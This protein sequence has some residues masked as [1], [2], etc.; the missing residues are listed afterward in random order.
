MS[1]DPQGSTSFT[2]AARASAGSSPEIVGSGGLFFDFDNDGWLDVFLV[3]GGSL[4]DGVAV[5]A[6]ATAYAEPRQRNL[7][8]V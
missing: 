6:R 8:S 3:D 5:T 2:P 4:A 7:R 1:P